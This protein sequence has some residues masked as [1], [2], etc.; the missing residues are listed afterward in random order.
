[1]DD[2]REKIGI[3]AAWKALE[4]VPRLYCDAIRQTSRLN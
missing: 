1:M 4:E 3:A 2:V